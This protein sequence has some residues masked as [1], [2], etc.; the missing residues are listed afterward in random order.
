MAAQRAEGHAPARRTTRKVLVLVLLLSAFL[1][2]AHLA[3]VALSEQFVTVRGDMKPADLMIVLGGDGPSR[4]IKARELWHRG[5]AHSVIVSGDGDCD[6]IRDTLV[7][8]GVPVDAVTTECQSGS[9]RENARFSTPL[10]AA[11]Q[12]R[13]AII[14]TSWF[15]TRRAIAT[16]TAACPRITFTAIPSEPPATLFET[17]FGHYG[18]A[19]AKEY[20]KLALYSLQNVSQNLWPDGSRP[21]WC[22]GGGE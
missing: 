15:H 18:P 20:A 13:S 6:Y 19:V 2:G 7:E 10:L 22:D 12:A 5:L 11:A 4:A 8:G 14:V 1:V 16:F 17:A 3:L 9:T 21:E